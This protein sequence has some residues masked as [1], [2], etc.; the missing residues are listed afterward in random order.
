[1][2]YIT[3][4]N[5]VDVHTTYKTIHTD[6]APDGGLFL[7]FSMPQLDYKAIEA[8]KDKSCGQNMAEILNLFFTVGLTGWDIDFAIGRNA[9]QNVSINN[10]LV[11]SEMWHNSHW[12]FDHL[13]QSISDRIRK[14]C[15]GETATNWVE[16][17]IS[18]ASLFGIYG[19]MLSVGQ[20]NPRVPLDI[21]VASGN[22][23]MP[24]AAWYAREMGLPIGNIICGC[25]A[26]GNVWELLHRGHM[27]PSAIASRTCT[28]ASDIVVPRNLER[29]I[30]GT[31]GQQ[32]LE[33]YLECCCV[34]T[35][36]QANEV[37]FEKLNAGF[38]ASVNSDS[39][40]ASVISNFYRTNHY[41]LSPYSAL[42]YGSLSDYRSKTGESRTALLLSEF[43]PVRDDRFV[44]GAM[45]ISV[46]EL[47]KILNLA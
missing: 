37:T 33:R 21:A 20:V 39:R 32:E 17:A 22:F 34:G 7:P 45:D 19:M 43:S 35:M 30:C 15:A 8:L 4:R 28:P 16:I 11:I 41:V 9:I 10:R 18:I 46:P 31:C 23:T 5:S 14:E 3:T 36:F 40:V 26:N 27:N 47:E 13:V 6:C 44:A 29:L 42:A 24:I 2:L 25:N 12:R 1:M 38:F